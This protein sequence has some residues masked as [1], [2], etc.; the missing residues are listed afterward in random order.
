MIAS[1]ATAL[2]SGKTEGSTK[3]IGT[4]V[5]STERVS[6]DMLT[7]KSAAVAG[8]KASVS[9]GLTKTVTSNERKHKKR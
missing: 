6:T 3:A 9:S 1:T 8:R 4:M 7:V 5:S 2:I